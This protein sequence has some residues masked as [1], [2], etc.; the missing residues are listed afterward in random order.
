MPAS[1]PPEF[2]MAAT[3]TCRA[4]PD[5]ERLGE[6]ITINWQ[7]RPSRTAISVPVDK[8]HASVRVAQDIPTNYSCSRGNGLG[9]FVCRVFPVPNSTS[10]KRHGLVGKPTCRTK[11][12]Q[13]DATGIVSR[14]ECIWNWGA[15]FN[16]LDGLKVD[17]RSPLE[18]RAPGCHR[19]PSCRG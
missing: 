8:Y 7:Q 19:W 13:Y 3:V 18:W 4:N 1:V 10:V 5:G 11:D 16:G 14:F 15:R 6:V 2:L 12:L 17:C 9:K